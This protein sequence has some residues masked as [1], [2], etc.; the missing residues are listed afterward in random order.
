MNTLRI[1]FDGN[2]FDCLV[3]ASGTMG[4]VLS[5][6]GITIRFRA[7]ASDRWRPSTA[8]QGAFPALNNGFAYIPDDG[9]P[10][11]Q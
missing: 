11:E 6:N 1:P 3:F 8:S 7:W 10:A 2:P 5:L 9:Y 4:G